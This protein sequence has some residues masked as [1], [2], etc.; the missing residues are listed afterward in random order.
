MRA[1]ERPCSAVIRE[2]MSRKGQR[3]R[4]ASRRPTVDLPAPIKP[5][6]TTRLGKDSGGGMGEDAGD[7]VDPGGPA[8]I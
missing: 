2:S 1:I 8:L 4:S 5:V 3:R 7:G 6:R